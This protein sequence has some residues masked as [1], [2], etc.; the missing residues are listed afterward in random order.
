MPSRSKVAMLPKNLRDELERRIVERAFSG[1]EE[2]AGWLQQQGYQIAEDS[3]QR[4]GIRLFQKMESLKHSVLQAQAIAH[5]A[6][7]DR[8]SIVDITID[9]L[10]ERVFT[11]LMEAEQL[12]P[13]EIVRFARIVSELSRLSIA[14]QG[15]AHKMNH[16]RTRAEQGARER[17]IKASCAEAFAAVRKAVSAARAFKADTAAALA[18]DSGVCSAEFNP[19]RPL[20]ADP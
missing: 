14:R 12:G 9:L 10:N 16:L 4:Y 18:G 15:W 13:A 8:D 6:P 2:L 3:V 5:Q 7:E 1:Y 11:S 17:R 20:R 19:A